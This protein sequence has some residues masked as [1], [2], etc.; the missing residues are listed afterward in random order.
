MIMYSVVLSKAAE[1]LEAVHTL[2]LPVCKQ[3]FL[4]GLGSQIRP[5]S[6]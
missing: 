2:G 4:D 6:V 3:Q 5:V 1:A